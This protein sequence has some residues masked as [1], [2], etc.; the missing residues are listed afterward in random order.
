MIILFHRGPEKSLIHFDGKLWHLVSFLDR[1]KRLVTKQFPI[2]RKPWKVAPNSSTI[3]GH[4][5]GDIVNLA[6]TMCKN[7]QFTCDDGGCIELVYV[8][9]IVF[10][11]TK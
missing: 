10:G 7:D 4:Q 9:H 2:G 6:M 8:R 5:P 11:G 1:T 3:C